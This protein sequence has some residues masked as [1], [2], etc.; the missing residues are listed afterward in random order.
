MLV[1]QILYLDRLNTDSLYYNRLTYEWLNS[2]VI[3][4]KTN[5]EELIAESI[6]VMGPKHFDTNLDKW[7]TELFLKM[8]ALD[9]VK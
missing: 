1:N 8:F 4:K 7:A 6:L 5:K 9:E 2:Y 3:N